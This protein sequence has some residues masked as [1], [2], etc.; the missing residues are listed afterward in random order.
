[1][2]QRKGLYKQKK[3]IE[4]IR[5]KIPNAKIIF[6]EQGLVDVRGE[7]ANL[8]D[9]YRFIGN[10]KIVRFFTDSK[11]KGLGEVI[12]LIFYFPFTFCSDCVIFKISGRYFLNENFNI[13][14]WISDK[15]VILIKEKKYIS[16]RFYSFNSKM[17]WYWILN[18]ILIIPF[19]F[20]NIS[21]ERLMLFVVPKNKIKSIETIGLS[22][23][24]GVNGDTIDE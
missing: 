12:G 14:Q 8:V 7:I 19:L 2:D 17:K 16:T 15:F 10:K 1:M 21:I 22:G 13:K 4:S 6:L 9:V 24:I 11:F 23:L 5:L 20:L 18:I 3:T